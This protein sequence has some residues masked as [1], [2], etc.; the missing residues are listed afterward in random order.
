MA[1][2]NGKE[3]LVLT[4]A[5]IDHLT[6]ERGYPPTYR[7]LGARLGIAHSAVYYRVR[8]LARDGL[9]HDTPG[10]ARGL[11][12]TRT[13]RAALRSPDVDSIESPDGLEPHTGE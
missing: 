6:R 1:R 3:A 12:V 5:A 8:D 10:I 11:R 4:L 7:D 9:V 2:R 13:G